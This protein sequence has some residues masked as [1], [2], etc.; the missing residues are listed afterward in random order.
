MNKPESQHPNREV[1]RNMHVVHDNAEPRIDAMIGG[2]EKGGTT[3][4]G[5]YVEQHPRVLSH[6][7]GGEKPESIE[8]TVFVDGRSED[9]GQ[10]RRAFD[11]VFPREPVG[12][13]IVLA[14]SVGILHLPDAARR[15]HRHNPRCRLIFS[16]RNPVD[17]AYSSFWY[18]VWRGEEEAATFEEGLERE[19]ERRR[20]GI[21]DPH[22]MYVGK[23]EYVRHLQN[24]S[25]L[26]GG[27]RLHVV[28]LEDLVE[29]PAETV[30]A[31]FE[32]LG[33]E[34][35]PVQKAGRKN[36]AKRPRWAWLSQWTRTRD[37]ARTVYRT[38]V[39]RRVREPLHWWLRRINTVEGE[40]PP[41]S[42]STRMRLVEH[43]VPFN[44]EL[45][46]FLGRS[47]D[48]WNR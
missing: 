26:F 7:S 6:L 2:V 32:F 12:E 31:V 21:R 40:Y 13:E 19:R 20:S 27:D 39:P 44:R 25:Y 11:R 43:F 23:G 41:M 28:L 48:G 17:R 4:L 8:F 5:A 30:N 10:Y 16:L 35:R 47:L 45:E 38:V 9:P 24:I 29:A 18:Q 42:E 22:R 46:E 33:L 15:L 37:P 36:K 34:S 14:K 1:A 3:S